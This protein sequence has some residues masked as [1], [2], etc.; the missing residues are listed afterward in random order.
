MNSFSMRTA[1]HCLHRLSE[2]R[3][4]MTTSQNPART[5]QMFAAQDKAKTDTEHM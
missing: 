3:I 2:Y 4:S 5:V 1:A